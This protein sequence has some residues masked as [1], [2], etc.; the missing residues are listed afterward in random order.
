MKFG[1]CF[2]C[3]QQR[4][5][6]IECPT[7]ERLGVRSKTPERDR[8]EPGRM[9]IKKEVASGELL[10]DMESESEMSSYRSVPSICVSAKVKETL[11]QT[12][13]DCGAEGDI[14]SEKVVKERN[15]PTSPI[16]PV[17]VGQALAKIGKTTVDRKV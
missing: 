13:I 3:R 15:L 17:R 11:L 5:R 7:R 4:H 2:L 1:V 6:A 10:I 16:Y 9:E 8:K 12:L 14:I